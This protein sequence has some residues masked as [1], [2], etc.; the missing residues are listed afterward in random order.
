MFKHLQIIPILLGILTGYI[1]FFIVKT[2]DRET[3]TKYP[4]PMNPG[5]STYR[6][7]N[8]LCYVFKREEIGCST[9]IDKEIKSYPLN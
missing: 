2:N 1:V 8:G 6:D 5:Q 4:D 3:V 9:A 7:K